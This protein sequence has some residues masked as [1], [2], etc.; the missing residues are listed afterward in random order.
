MAHTVFELHNLK[1][2][3]SK[4]QTF[5]WLENQGT[6]KKRSELSSFNGGC[7]TLENYYTSSTSSIV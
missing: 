3:A 5:A 1:E 2:N 4:A 7:L 6:W